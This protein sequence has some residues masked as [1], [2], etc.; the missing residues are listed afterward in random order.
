MRSPGRFALLAAWLMF[1]VHGTAQKDRHPPKPLWEPPGIQWPATGTGGSVIHRL[2][3]GGFRIVLDQTPLQEARRILGGT[4][5]YRGNAGDAQSWL[6][7][8]GS[9]Q[10]GPWMFWLTSVEINGNAVGG[11]IWRRSKDGDSAGPGCRVLQGTDQVQLPSPLQLGMEITKAEGILG[12]PTSVHESDFFYMNSREE[13]VKEER[14]TIDNGLEI[15]A[16]AG[17]IVE[18]AAFETSSN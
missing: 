10:N 18:I 2:T 11:F 1:A 7:Y 14:F 17:V 12:K 8:R 15:R 5:G 3:V 13:T 4:I 6:C 9:D 16:Q